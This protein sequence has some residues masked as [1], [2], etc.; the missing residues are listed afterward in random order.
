MSSADNA[1]STTNEWPQSGLIR[2]SQF[3]PDL[4]ISSVTVWR[5]LK[6][7]RFP[8]PIHI[9]SRLRLWRVEDLREWMKIGPDEW[10]RLHPV[11]GAVATIQ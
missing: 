6:D 5:M 8:Q 10:A 1:V 2:R 3:A 7:G 11:G 9:S 4:K